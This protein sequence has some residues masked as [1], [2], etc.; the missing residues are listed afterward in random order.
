MYDRESIVFLKQNNGQNR[1][2]VNKMLPFWRAMAGNITIDLHLS[3]SV[4]S[5]GPLLPHLNG[6]VL[7]CY[8]LFLLH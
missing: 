2:Q 1:L 7:P 5:T 3:S 8:R 6:I 4:N